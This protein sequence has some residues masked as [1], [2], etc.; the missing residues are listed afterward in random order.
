[1]KTTTTMNADTTDNAGDGRQLQ[2]NAD[3]RIRHQA[4]DRAG[5]YA[6]A[7]GADAVRRLHLLHKIYSPAGTRVLLQAGLKEGM[8]VADFGCGVGATTRML[9]EMVGPWEVSQASI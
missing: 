7:T 9:A 6:L 1:M 4:G 8:R 5:A 2:A 3:R